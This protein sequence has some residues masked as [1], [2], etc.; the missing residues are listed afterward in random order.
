MKINPLANPLALDTQ[1]GFSFFADW[2][3]FEQQVKEEKERAKTGGRRPSD[4]VKGER[5]AKDRKANNG[6]RPGG[7]EWRAEEQHRNIETFGQGS[8]D[9]GYRGYRGRGRGRGGR[10]RGGYGGRGRG[11]YRG[12][13]NDAQSVPQ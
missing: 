9:G 3:R 13:R 11:G 1:A 10:G 6:S 12:P 8:V 2:W 7:R 4:R 5:E